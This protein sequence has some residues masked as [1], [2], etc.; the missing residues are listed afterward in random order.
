MCGIWGYIGKNIDLSTAYKSFN[1]IQH[2]GPDVS[3]FKHINNIGYI[4]F[5]RLSIINNT[6][7][8]NQPFLNKQLNKKT[9]SLCNGEIYNHTNLIEHNNKS[10]CYVI[11][12]LYNLGF[13]PYELIEGEYAYSILDVNDDNSFNLQLANDHM[14]IR[15]LFYA[16]NSNGIG[17]SSEVKGLLDIFPGEYI[18]RFLPGHYLNLNNTFSEAT[19][20][21]YNN[22]ADIKTS[23]YDYND[24]IPLIENTLTKC[25]DEMIMS[26]RPIGCLLS[27]GLDSSVISALVSLK[28]KE[29]NRQ[30][31]T[32]SVGIENSTDEYYARKVSEHINSKHTHFSFTTQ[33]FLN[34]IPEV[35]NAIESYDTT[36][37]RA[38]VGQYLVSKKIRETTDIKVLLVGD[39]S[40]EL[41]SGYIYSH[42]APDNL[43]LHRDSIRLLNNI[44]LYDGLRADRGIASNGMETRIPFLHKDFVN[45]YLS[46]DPKL[47]NPNYPNI[48]TE[49][50]LLRKAFQNYLPQEVVWRKKEAFSDGV[51][52][53]ENSW[54][55]S[56]KKSLNYEEYYDDLTNIKNPP[57][58][59]EAMYYRNIFRKLFPNCDHVI[60]KY[61]LPRWSG[62]TSEPSARV[63]KNY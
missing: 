22:I 4:G 9:Y 26:D 31:S 6:I 1:R 14:G 8:G 15:P 46:I 57:L 51:S 18:K 42:N 5:H 20:K 59:V 53:L 58:T 44:H 34:A 24:A 7:F 30:L 12:H 13:N 50:W 10:D 11:P 52:G 63:L 19:P 2:R 27:G 60:P 17:W 16:I 43:E 48:P 38:S 55:M 39:G 41:T 35:I 45:L 37:V 49:K 36:S 23:I 40:D 25:V 33:E 21:R 61:W 56:I 29:S 62:Q 54:F 28:L 32:F 3:T 47:R